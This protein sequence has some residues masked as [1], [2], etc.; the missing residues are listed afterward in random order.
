M[1]SGKGVR[2]SWCPIGQEYCYPS[3]YFRRGDRCGFK[4]SRGRQIKEL[5]KRTAKN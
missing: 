5:K 1:A 2:V 4:S 3:C